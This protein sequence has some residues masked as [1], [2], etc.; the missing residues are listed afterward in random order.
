MTE[1]EYITAMKQIL[2][3][4]PRIQHIIDAFN[5][6]LQNRVFTQGEAYSAELGAET[7]AL[8]LTFSDDGQVDD[9]QVEGIGFYL[10]EDSA[11]ENPRISTDGMTIRYVTADGDQ[12]I[13]KNYP[14]LA[15]VAGYMKDIVERFP[16]FE[17]KFWDFTEVKYREFCGN[18]K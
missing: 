5:D 14:Q 10:P 8:G 15:R 1:Y 17:K 6:C 18:S 9:G 4:E 13:F 11:M 3:L 2:D 12:R 7:Y 16:R